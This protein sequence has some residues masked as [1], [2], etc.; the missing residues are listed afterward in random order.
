EPK[1]KDYVVGTGTMH[2]VRDLCAAAFG[3]VGLEW[4]K[5]VK[6]DPRFV[7]PAEVDTL[8][9]D[10]SRAR[11]E[12]GWMPKVSFEQLVK[13]MVDADMERLA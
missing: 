1:P 9:A 4:K 10:A 5:Y 8:L 11:T 13:M 2:T 6:T 7:R 12:L 3:H